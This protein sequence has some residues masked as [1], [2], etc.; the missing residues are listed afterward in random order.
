MTTQEPFEPVPFEVVREP[1]QLKAFADPLR[2]RVLRL[3]K[4]RAATNGQ[5]AAALGE[6][7]A[8]VL[9][10]VR[11]LLDVGLIRL[12]EQR[13][14]GGNVEKYYRATARLYGLRPAEEDEP[15][16]L[17]APLLEATLQE[18]VASHASFP[19]QPYE[20]EG[21]RLRLS[22]E[23]LAAFQTRLHDVVNEFFGCPEADAADP[24][25]PAAWR[26][27]EEDDSAPVACFT[28]VLYRAPNEPGQADLPDLPQD[29]SES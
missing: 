28:M 3:L 29:A 4:E 20:S 19:D 14:T 12:V 10:H 8:K 9:H 6:P 1:R 27:P 25:D 26:Q 5:V 13:V 16:G 17:V 18:V 23:R 21:R 11:V 22:P 15:V 24:D 7:P 2:L